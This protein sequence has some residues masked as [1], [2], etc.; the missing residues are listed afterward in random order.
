MHAFHGMLTAIVQ[1]GEIA[2]DLV[3]TAKASGV[4]TGTVHLPGKIKG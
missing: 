1:A 2:G 4:K 3:L